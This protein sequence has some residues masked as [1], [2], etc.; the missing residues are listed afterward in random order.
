MTDRELKRLRRQDLLEI[1]I[2]QRKE[3]ESL[4]ERLARAEAS[5]EDRQIRIDKAGSLAEAVLAVNGVIEA[6]QSA[7]DQ[8]L[9]NIKELSSQQAAVCEQREKESREKAETLLQE[10][11]EQSRALREKC[12]ADCQAMEMKAKQASEAYWARVAANLQSFCESHESLRH[13]L[14]QKGLWPERERDGEEE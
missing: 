8:Y 5:L 10:A 14:D 1:L 4:K 11:E 2:A 12:E 9:D 6:A 3:I 7:A 13:L